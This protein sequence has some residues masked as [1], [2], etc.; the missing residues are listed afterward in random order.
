MFVTEN[1]RTHQWYAFVWAAS[2]TFDDGSHGDRSLVCHVHPT[3]YDSDCSEI[4]TFLPV[5]CDD[6]FLLHHYSRQ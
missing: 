5:E 3:S 4:R 6:V 1:L 2:S